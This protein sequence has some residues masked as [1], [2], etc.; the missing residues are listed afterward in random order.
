MRSEELQIAIDWARQ[1]GWNPGL[2]DS[3]VFYAADPTG[4]FIGE[5]NSEVISVANAV[6]YDMNASFFG[7]YIVK[8]AY[9][10]QGYGLKMTEHRLDYAGERNAGLDGVLENV[11]MYKK[12]GFKP[13]YKNQ[14][15]VHTGQPH[16]IEN[17][18]IQSIHSI[19]FD[20]LLHYDQSCFFGERSR[21]LK[22]WISQADSTALVYIKNNTIAGYGVCRKCYEGFKIGP[23]FA[24]N[25]D[26]AEALFLALQHNKIGEQIFIDIPEINKI[27]EDLV[28]KYRMRSIFTVMRMYRKYLPA[29]AYDKIVGI[30]TYELG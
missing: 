22:K 7:L 25:G 6:N 16:T 21:F 18:R 29:L 10:G 20:E 17:S 2:H 1:E 30:T 12:K 26:I 3:K 19:P 27:G 9:R 11:D 8:K 13:F 15:F 14:R 4:F 24:D 28:K 23:L 5:L